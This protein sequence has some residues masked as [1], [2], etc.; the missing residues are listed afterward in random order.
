MI[1]NIELTKMFLNTKIPRYV[2]EL[3]VNYMFLNTS[4]SCMFLNVPAYQHILLCFSV[5]EMSIWDRCSWMSK[6]FQRSSIFQNFTEFLCF[7]LHRCSW[8]L[9]LTKCFIYENYFIILNLQNSMFLNVPWHQYHLHFPQFLRC[10]RDKDIPEFT[11]SLNVPEYKSDIQVLFSN[12]LIVFLNFIVSSMFLNFNIPEFNVILIFRI[13]NCP[14]C[15]WIF[16]DI[17]TTS[18]FL[19]VNVTHV[20]ESDLN[21]PE[22][23]RKCSWMQQ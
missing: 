20:S 7:K 18:L 8:I 4:L 15:S 17:N 21:V 22:C 13:Q 11:N 1:L 2:P 5:S 14:L 12:W 9:K 19:S 3:N 10:Q 16:L 6:W 23:S